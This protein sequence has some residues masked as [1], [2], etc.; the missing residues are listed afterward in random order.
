MKGIASIP[1]LALRLPESARLAAWATGL[2]SIVLGI[3][4]AHLTWTVLVPDPA[5]VS[6]VATTNTSTAARPGKVM[7]LDV[8][9]AM[10]LFGHSVKKVE[11]PKVQAP[12]DAPDTRLNL[13]LK[14][15]M[16]TSDPAL[17]GALISEGSGQEK[18]YRLDDMLP[19]GAV[20]K[21]V[22]AD[23]VLLQRNGRFE[24]LRLPKEKMTGTTASAKRG[25]P[26]R[27]T[28]TRRTSGGGSLKEYRQRLMENPAELWQMV[29]LE[30]VM[31]DNG[32]IKGYKVSP[33]KDKQL[34]QQ[35]GLRKGDIVTAI[36]GIP[37]SDTSQMGQA[38]NQLSTSSRFEITVDRNG[39]QQ[40]VNVDMN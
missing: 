14:G 17:A 12:I 19:G 7:G 34:F 26:P 29:R 18:H 22:H 24:T 10:H 36:N 35:L 13:K 2:M 25:A 38:L 11:A 21:E 39:R 31:Q 28:A 5:P 30:P 33:Q 16:A 4:F 20:L 3:V 1:Q 32:A 15:V 37:M 9:A 40:T 27:R 23:R 6:M 8:V